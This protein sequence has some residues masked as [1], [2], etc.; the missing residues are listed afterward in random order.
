MKSCV[1][2]YQIYMNALA[3]N[4]NLN[5]FA[6]IHDQFKQRHDGGINDHTVQTSYD[7]IT[8]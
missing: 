2:M 8:H 3:T 1:Q 6:I 7:S 4:L 5:T